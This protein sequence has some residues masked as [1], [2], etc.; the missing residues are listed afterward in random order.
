[1]AVANN[2]QNHSPFLH[3]S[4]FDAKITAVVH[5]YTDGDLKTT[6]LFCTSTFFFFFCYIDIQIIQNNCTTV[7]KKKVTKTI[8]NIHIT[9]LSNTHVQEVVYI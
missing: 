7:N 3:H 8:L 1:M 5:H 9:R 4:P 2:V 6:A